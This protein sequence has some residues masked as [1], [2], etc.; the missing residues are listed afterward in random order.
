MLVQFTE[1]HSSLGVNQS[2]IA[3]A[4]SEA[5]FQFLTLMHNVTDLSLQSRTNVKADEIILSLSEAAAAATA[6]NAQN[7]KNCF[8]IV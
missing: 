5:A 8:I 7:A 3:N 4:I 2:S 1:N 6:T